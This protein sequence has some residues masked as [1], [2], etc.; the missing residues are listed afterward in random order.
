MPTEKENI[1]ATATDETKA[2]AT[3]ED[4][5]ATQTKATP[6]PKTPPRPKAGPSGALPAVGR[7]A[8]RLHNLEQVWV[9]DDGQ[10]FPV[11]GDA[12]AHAANLRNNGIIKVT[13]K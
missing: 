2:E 12:K 5:S 13:A 8:C 10:C 7:E 11:E 3:V 1:T 9:T 4:S 6:K